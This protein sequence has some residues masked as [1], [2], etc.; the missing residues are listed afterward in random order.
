MQVKGKLR[1]I[2]YHINAA[3]FRDRE[4]SLEKPTN[5][6]RVA[7]L[8]DSFVAGLA[9]PVEEIFPSR[10]ETWLGR[11]RREGEPKAEVLSF[12]VVGYGTGLELLTLQQR[13]LA[14]APNVVVLSFFQNDPWDNLASLGSQKA[15]YFQLQE[16]GM[17]ELLSPR[18]AG[19]KR[20]RGLSLFLN[21][22]SRLYTYQ[23][24]LTRR[25][26]DSWKYRYRGGVSAL[27]KVYRPLTLPPI[28]GLDEAWK[29]TLA[30]VS[31]MREVCREAGAQFLVLDIPMQEA[32]SPTRRAFSESRFPALR[33]VSM[34]WDRSVKRLGNFC[35]R[36]G[37]PYL[38]LSPAML[39]RGE[40]G[41]D[42][43]LPEDGHLS[44]EGHLRVGAALA[45]F[46]RS[47][48]LWK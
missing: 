40:D 38:D 16:G 41:A 1:E 6:R 23:K 37:I 45:E 34:E 18:Q 39:Q 42:F 5:V 2:P 3:G 12:G 25:I 47:R 27:P 36:E 7:V 11:G 4:H 10:L 17:L 15:P 20:R 29:L 32:I 44:A 19:K 8:G 31:R 9:V 24:F 13:A 46:M 21:S 14:F 28:K 43:Y 35:Q 22:Y 48:G 26:V 33:E 30:L